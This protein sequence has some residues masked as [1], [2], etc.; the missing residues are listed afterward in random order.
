MTALPLSPRQ[1]TFS[2]LN[3]ARRLSAVNDAAATTGRLSAAEATS[4]AARAAAHLRLPLP[5][6]AG[7]GT[8]E[9]VAYASSSSVYGETDGS[10]AAEGAGCADRPLSMYA[11]SKRSTELLASSYASMFHLPSTGLR[12]FTVYGTHGRP[13]MAV[14]KFTDAVQGGRP[15]ALT[16]TSAFKRD[17]THVS[18]IVEGIVCIMLHPPPLGTA[19]AGVDPRPHTVFNIGRADPVTVDELISIIEVAASKK[20][21]VQRQDALSVDVTSTHADVSKLMGLCG[22]S[23]ATSLKDGVT[24]F[25]RWYQDYSAG[26]SACAAGWPREN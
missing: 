20:A 10:A 26:K 9:H 16:A 7:R 6:W 17:F 18:D 19:A 14:W 25:V 11:A 2:I 22:K 24:A 5:P 23:P 8:V 4:L 12:F 1:G 3:A 21:I 13:D 15:I